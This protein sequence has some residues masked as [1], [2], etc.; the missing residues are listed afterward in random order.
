VFIMGF[1]RRD[2]GGAGLKTMFDSG[3]L[4]DEQVLVSIVT[5]TLFIPC[6]ANFLVMARERGWK[7]AFAMAAFIVPVA[8]LTGGAVRLL[9]RSGIL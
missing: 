1:L 9:L 4:T 7:T 3:Q 5:L 8:V 2:Y 6:V